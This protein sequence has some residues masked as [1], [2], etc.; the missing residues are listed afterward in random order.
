MFKSSSS[1]YDS[2]DYF[3]PIHLDDLLRKSH[4]WRDIQEIIRETFTSL[5]EVVK[6]Q[7]KSLRDLERQLSLKLNKSE[8][9]AALSHKADYTQVSEQLAELRNVAESRSSLIDMQSRIDE[10]VS[11]TELRHL[12]SSKATVQDLNS[13]R[14]STTSQKEFE[15]AVQDI[16]ERLDQVQNQKGVNFASQEYEDLLNRLKSKAEVSEV[17]RMLNYLEES[18][19]NL[20]S[21]KATRAEVENLL[22]R[23]ADL[24]ELDK[25]FSLLET[26]ANSKSIEQLAKELETKVNT[27]Y[28][29]QNVVQ[30]LYYKAD[31]RD[32]E[33]L[34]QKLREVQLESQKA[35]Q[36]NSD[37]MQ[38][39]TKKLNEEQE[40]LRNQLTSSIATKAENKEI[41]QI[42]GIIHKKV[43]YE[44]YMER[45]ETNNKEIQDSFNYKVKTLKQQL[46][47]QESLFEGKT[48]ENYNYC[49]QL[50]SG[51]KQ[52][53]ENLKKAVDKS[54]YLYEENIKFC[55]SLCDDYNTELSNQIHLLSEEVEK[56]QSYIREVSNEK[57]SKDELNQV[58]VN[59]SKWV[60]EKANQ[61]ELEKAVC[62]LQKDYTKNNQELGSDFKTKLYKLE[63]E[64][65]NKT[66]QKVSYSELHSYLS[67]KADITQI[68][69]L[70][71]SKASQDEVNEVKKAQEKLFGELKVRAGKEELEKHIDSTKNA[72]EEVGK[73]ILLKASIKDVCSLMDQKAN[74]EDVNN[75]LSDVHKELDFKAD[76][77]E[78]EDFQN[79]QRLINEA[80]CSEN[81]VGRW[82]WKTADMKP[83]SGVP[84]EIQSV[85]TCPENFLWE[86]YSTSIVVVAPGLYEIMFGFYSKKKPTVQLLINGEPVLSAV[87]N[88][89]YVIHHSSGRL[90]NT[91]HHSSGNVTGLTLIDFLAL[92]SRARV[93]LSYNG[94]TQ[95]EGFLGLRKL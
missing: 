19:N 42:L 35:I 33:S 4:E 12:L 27:Q 9:H 5:T 60:K 24:C 14:E 47:E 82:V 23:K 40:V 6:A 39:F 89:S 15:A 81:T 90:K 11:Q 65:L 78:F 80:L 84:W 88:A 1:R 74:V 2:V 55:K 13:L 28:L 92:P 48:S 77:T 52:L 85:N 79:E 34:N 71:S 22:S 31:T 66:D 69:R 94:D 7:G 16:Y 29:E 17:E 18:Q 30:P 50:D 32:V 21:K 25:A 75:A 59:L 45:L 72:L 76:S 83:G 20:M 54:N 53:Q 63:S 51:I 8:F 49:T 87:N 64:I 86:P 37:E 56:N 10:K 95:A 3:N 62:A 44:T 46:S 91:G 38:E 61:S 68:N 67:E 41:D 58:Q 57:V 36:K 73:D 70:L 26:K 43:D 93:S